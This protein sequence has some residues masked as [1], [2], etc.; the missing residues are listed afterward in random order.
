MTYTAKVKYV[1]FALRFL[2]DIAKAQ[3][4]VIIG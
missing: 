3:K 1:C 2:V 4:Y